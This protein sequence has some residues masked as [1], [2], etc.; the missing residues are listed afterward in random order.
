[1]NAPIKP[2][3][4]DLYG[5][6]PH[7]PGSR[8]GPGDHTVTQQQAD[9]FLVDT[10][11][12]T[13]R[14]IVQEKLDGSCTGVARIGD[15]IIPLQRKGYPAITSP[16]EQHH[17]FHDWAMERAQD[18]L[19]VLEDGERDGGREVGLT[20]NQTARLLHA[21]SGAWPSVSMKG[22]WPGTIEFV[23]DAGEKVAE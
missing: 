18:F 7:L 3:G 9:L 21:V 4:G 13:R 17:L 12:K 23:V 14:V 19:S 6:I 10:M 15:Q 8:V 22:A 20:A 1:M 16:Y 11:S 5:S 2:L